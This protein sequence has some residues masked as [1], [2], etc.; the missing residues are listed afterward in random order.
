M[1][2]VQFSIISC[3]LPFGSISIA[4]RLSNPL[5]LVASLLNFWEKASERLCAGSVDCACQLGRGCVSCRRPELLLAAG[6]T[7][8]QENRFADF[9]EL[10]S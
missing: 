10:H 9:G 6:E 7:Y 4:N 8:D 3:K 5:T 1:P 2:D